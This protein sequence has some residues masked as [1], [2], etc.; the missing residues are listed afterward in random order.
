[1][2][3]AT[4]VG[5]T[6]A[7]QADRG[8]RVL[9]GSTL[10][11]RQTAAA[12]AAGAAEAG[13]D[14]DVDGPHVAFALRNPDLYVAAERVD[15]VSSSQAPADQVDWLDADTAA[16]VPFFRGFIQAED[17]IGWWVTHPDPPGDDA[18][19]IVR[20]INDFAASLADLGPGAPLIVAVA[21][22]PILRSANS[23]A[24]PSKSR[25]TPNPVKS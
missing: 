10:R 14:V 7:K 1:M 22:S 25:S 15:I 19:A 8:L 9:T 12:I 23:T 3:F 4:E 6:L 11:T 18:M 20:R 5:R 13:A 24:P 21:H 16:K 2:A 17:R